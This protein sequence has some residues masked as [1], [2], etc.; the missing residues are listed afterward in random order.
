M[1]RYVSRTSRDV[2]ERDPPRHVAVRHER[3]GRLVDMD[4]GVHDEQVGQ[5]LAR[6]RR[7]LLRDGRHGAA[8]PAGSAGGLDGDRRRRAR[9]CR[10]LRRSRSSS[11]GSD[12]SATPSSSRK[13][14]SGARC[15]QVPE[16][17]QS[18]GSTD[19]CGLSQKARWSDL[20]DPAS[21][22]GGT[23]RPG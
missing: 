15:T 13:K 14:V 7:R 6:L 5:R 10:A 1:S 2:L 4:V 8:P 9:P 21:C 18:T 22:R 23:V 17:M 3:R 20:T 12:T 19:T 16:P 11:M